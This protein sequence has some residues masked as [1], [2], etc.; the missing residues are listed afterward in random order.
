MESSNPLHSGLSFQKSP[1]QETSLLTWYNFT[2]IVAHITVLPAG[3]ITALSSSFDKTA[4]SEK[5][6]QEE[7]QPLQGSGLDFLAFSPGDLLVNRGTFL[8]QQQSGSTVETHS[9][10]ESSSEGLQYRGFKEATLQT[11][12][13]DIDRGLINKHTGQAHMNTVLRT[14]DRLV[15]MCLEPLRL[16]ALARQFSE[17]QSDWSASGKVMHIIIRF[18]L[19]WDTQGNVMRVPHVSFSLQAPHILSD[20]SSC[21][22]C[23]GTDHQL[24]DCVGPPNKFLGVILGCPECND[25]G[26]QFDDCPKVTGTSTEAPM[27]L[28]RR[29]E[30][31]VVKRQDKP[32]IGTRE[33][34][35]YEDCKDLFHKHHIRGSPWSPEFGKQQ[36]NNGGPWLHYNYQTAT[37]PLPKD[38]SQKRTL[39]QIQFRTFYGSW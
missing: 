4:V 17:E 19:P 22:L 8:Q 14:S 31:L 16:E 11:H 5:R 1:D 18:L 37:P 13:I 20:P 29:F 38:P 32:M 24:E 26:H 30:L 2:P 39:Q 27:S 15:V 3:R 7:Y 12:R 34:F 23:A 25:M 28:D 35:D 36:F 6:Q 9:G 33:A 21:A 10:H